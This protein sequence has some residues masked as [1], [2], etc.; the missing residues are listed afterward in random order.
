MKVQ[1]LNDAGGVI[2]DFDGSSGSGLVSTDMKV[3]IANALHDATAHL[4]QDTH[5]IASITADIRAAVSRIETELG[6][7]PAFT[8][9][10][11]KLG[12]AIAHLEAQL[13]GL[14][15]EPQQALVPAGTGYD[16]RGVL[17]K[18]DPV[19]AAAANQAATPAA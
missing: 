7:H 8:W 4:S 2:F 3:D 14:W 17:V 9:A 13:S 19:A 18:L 15:T 1:V 12:N 10:E 16:V 6:A 5:V 11:T